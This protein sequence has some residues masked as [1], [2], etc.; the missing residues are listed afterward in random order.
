MKTQEDYIQQYVSRIDGLLEAMLSREAIT[1][2]RP[3]CPRCDTGRYAVWRCQDCA[4]GMP[5][6]RGCMRTSHKD[7]PFH[8]IELWNGSFFQPAHLWE[9]GAY[10]LI[11]HH[12]RKPV[13]AILKEQIEFLEAAETERDMAEQQ[14]LNCITESF[15]SRNESTATAPDC[16]MITR[17]E[18][19]DEHMDGPYE[20]YPAFLRYLD[21]DEEDDSDEND[22]PNGKEEEIT[23]A[24]P[25]YLPKNATLGTAGIHLLLSTYVRV[26]HVNGIHN[27]AMVSC[28]CHGADNLPLD[29]V[30]SRLLPASFHRIRT[31]F[32]A[33]A[34]DNFRLCNLELKASAYQY[35]Q[36]LRRL[37][38]PLAPGEV[39]NLYRE[40]RRMSRIWRWMKKLKWAG[41][42]TG[43]KPVEEVKSGEL[44]TYC[45]ACPQPGINIPEDWKNDP[46]RQVSYVN[47]SGHIG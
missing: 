45:L 46:A 38:A 37:T 42:G 22:D 24:L 7:N 36:L 9:V 4:L 10:L 14:R 12:I 47:Y 29:L 28:E 21:N 27:I 23:P 11:R 20:D 44:A 16:D 41:Y 5:M 1:G 34:L 31:L 13:C 17:P 19:P 39:V 25:E 35:Y 40:F 18:G 3:R 32:S 6:C 15:W 33:Q 30:A 8:H 43:V 2:D 26:I